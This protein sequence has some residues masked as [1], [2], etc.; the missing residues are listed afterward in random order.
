MTGRVSGR[1]MAMSPKPKWL[2]DAE[3]KAYTPPKKEPDKCVDCA[4]YGPVVG[5]T[6]HKGKERT[7]IHEC[8]IHPGCL[9]TR[10]SICC[11]DWTP[12]NLL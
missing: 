1:S 3:A 5:N 8:D 9:N 2:K 7:S 4:Y 10:F 11:S 6:K 12:A